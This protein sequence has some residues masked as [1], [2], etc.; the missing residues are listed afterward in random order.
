MGRGVRRYR[1]KSHERGVPLPIPMALEQVA[2]STEH[3]RQEP[4]FANLAVL[5]SYGAL[6]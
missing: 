5:E 1:G 4:K 2:H 3:G 6:R